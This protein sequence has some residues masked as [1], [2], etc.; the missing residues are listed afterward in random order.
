MSSK[1]ECECVENMMDTLVVASDLS[2]SAST[3]LSHNPNIINTAADI[4]KKY[5]EKLENNCVIPTKNPE[6]NFFMGDRYKWAKEDLEKVLKSKG[7]D[8]N[9]AVKAGDRFHSFILDNGARMIRCSKKF[10]SGELK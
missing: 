2:K 3:K 6:I 4:L 7:K 10:E 1:E 8:T 9:A 5:V